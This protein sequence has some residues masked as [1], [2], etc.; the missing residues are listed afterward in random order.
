MEV[1]LRVTFGGDAGRLLVSSE[2]RCWTVESWGEVV[3]YIAF[4]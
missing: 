2:A 3:V 4:S 1:D